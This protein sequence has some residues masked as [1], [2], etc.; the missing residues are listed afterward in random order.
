MMNSDGKP[1]NHRWLWVVAAIIGIVIAVHLGGGAKNKATTEASAPGIGQVAKD[2]DFAFVVKRI[3]CGAA[4]AAAVGG[5]FG[6]TVPAG[7][8]ECLITMTV[9][10]DTGTAQTFY[11]SNQYGYDA[12]GRKYSADESASMSLA[13]DQDGTQLNPGISI[14]AVVPFQIP[15]SVN[16]TQVELHDSMFSGGVSVRL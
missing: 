1:Q 6:D 10:D 4:A 15:T 11:D 7:A 16:L 13:G 12:A 3:Q 9:T 14:H 2:G 8:K 5:L